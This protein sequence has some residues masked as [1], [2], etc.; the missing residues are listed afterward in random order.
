MTVSAKLP[1]AGC[2][3]ML[4]QL[5]D[6]AAAS[7]HLSSG[8][9]D[10]PHYYVTVPASS[11]RKLCD[12]D[13][14]DASSS[15]TELRFQVGDE[16]IASVASK[17]WVNGVVT[18]QWY[19]DPYWEDREERVPYQIR[20][21]GL[22][23][24]LIWC[25]V[26]D[27]CV[28]RAATEE[29]FRVLG[30]K[31]LP[32]PPEHKKNQIALYDALDADPGGGWPGQ[33]SCCEKGSC[34]RATRLRKKLE[35]RRRQMLP[36]Q[37]DAV[38]GSDSSGECGG[39]AK[40]A[41]ANLDSLMAWI[42]EESA[43]GG[44]AQKKRKKKKQRQQRKQEQQQQRG[45]EEGEQQQ[46]GQEQLQAVVAE[47]QPLPPPQQQQ[48]QQ[49]QVLGDCS[50]DDIESFE[51]QLQLGGASSRPV[52]RRLPLKPDIRWALIRMCDSMTSIAPHSHRPPP[53]R[54]AGRVCPAH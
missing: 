22:N 30:A 15:E 6:A 40:A 10:G 45:E 13:A 37:D 48:Q 54:C 25:P 41:G 51:R 53:D 32:P 36:C 52:H 29:N 19:N 9:Q 31:R 5:A 43:A 14:R 38:S 24:K 1:F 42:N 27:D 35:E 2:M 49:A 44:A 50:D 39:P 18:Q 17:Q 3:H 47:E 33:C 28:V 46:G 4:E 26:D 8:E 23:S 12:D 11:V 7:A 20:L 16:V 21:F 34:D